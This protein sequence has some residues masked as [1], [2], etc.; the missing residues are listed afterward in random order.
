MDFSNLL[1]SFSATPCLPPHKT[2]A[3]L[4]VIPVAV[5]QSYETDVAKEFVIR[6]NDALF[7]CSILNF[8]LGSQGWPISCRQSSKLN[9]LFI[10]Q[11]ISN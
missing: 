11:I 8:I 7:K 4:T 9:A 6:G 3:F 2:R 5:F 10:L 1:Y